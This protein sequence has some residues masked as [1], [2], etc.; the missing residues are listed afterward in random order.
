VRILRKKQE[1]MPA[2]SAPIAPSRENVINLMNALR[3]SIAAPRSQRRLQPL[4]AGSGVARP[5]DERNDAYATFSW[6]PRPVLK[7]G[8]GRWALPVTH[9]DLGGFG[10]SSRQQVVA[11]SSSI[12][13]DYAPWSKSMISDKAWPRLIG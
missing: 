8:I 3:R 10:T 11:P 7:P 2:P 12:R 6:I 4:Q 1:K 13:T 9:G 5:A